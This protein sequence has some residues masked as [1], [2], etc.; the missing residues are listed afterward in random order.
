MIVQKCFF[1]W[2]LK[3]GVYSWTV[4]QLILRLGIMCGLYWIP[5]TIA[6]TGRE[7]V[8]SAVM[9]TILGAIFGW[10]VWSVL[11]LVVALKGIAER[12][13]ML[14]YPYMF[15]LILEF[16]LLVVSGILMSALQTPWYIFQALISCGTHGYAFICTISFYKSI[17]AQ[18]KGLHEV[19][20]IPFKTV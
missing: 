18:E 9:S 20:A 13:S 11:I 1:C 3:Y 19:E 4:I 7:K 14:V 5:D 8:L 6:D 16:V 12:R 17:K 15:L 2:S 10:L